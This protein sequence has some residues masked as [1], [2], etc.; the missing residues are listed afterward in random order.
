MDCIENVKGL[1]KETD[2]LK[3]NLIKEDQKINELANKNENE[4]KEIR[5][6][7]KNGLAKV[8]EIT[9]TLNQHTEILTEQSTTIA[10]IQAISLQNSEKIDEVCSLLFNHESR[11]KY[12]EGRVDKIEEVLKR[13]EESILNLTGDVSEMKKQMNEVLIR[14]KNLEQRVEKVERSLIDNKANSI[15]EYLDKMNDEQLYEVAN[16]ILELRNL[17]KPF[18][19]EKILNG[20]KL[21]VGKK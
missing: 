19:L 20:I 15:L 3:N 21:I 5:E 2:V 18:N 7:C 9:Q 1:Y 17:K 14:L 4:F 10:K 6:Q 12:L 11:I 16:F 13:H 8:N